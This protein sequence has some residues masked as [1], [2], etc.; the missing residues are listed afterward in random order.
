MPIRKNYEIK[1]LYIITIIFIIVISFSHIVFVLRNTDKSI[2]NREELI[3]REV[4][5]EFVF[6]EFLT[7]NSI[8]DIISDENYFYVLAFY[9]DVAGNSDVAKSI[10]NHAIEK[11]VPINLAFALAFAESSFN[12]NAEN[13]SNTNGTV[14]RGLFQLNSATFRNADY[15][16]IDVNTNLA[17]DYLITKKERYSSWESGIVMYNAGLEVNLSNRS[18]VYLSRIL[19]KEREYDERFNTFRRNANLNG[20][21]SQR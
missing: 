12:P 16:N 18:L 14:D 21:H 2:H 13:R 17:L 4:V 5:R 10:L 7:R 15:F 3:I 9:R 19:A 8:N 1:F 6:E 20:I 11:Q